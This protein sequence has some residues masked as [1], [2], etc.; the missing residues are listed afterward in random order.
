MAEKANGSRIKTGNVKRMALADL[1]PATYN[2]RTI[3]DLAKDGLKESLNKFG[4]LNLVV[5][6]E[7]SGNVVG[8]HQRLKVLQEQGETE[9]DVL[10]VSLDDKEEVAL[11][12]ALNNHAIQGDFSAE[13]LEA[14]KMT[15]VNLGDMFDKLQLKPIMNKLEKKIEK[16]KKKEAPM[17]KEETPEFEQKVTEVIIICPECK[18]RWRMRDGV[19][20][21][22]MVKK[23]DQQ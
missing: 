1:I 4:V 20:V 2:P 21:A 19:V 7:R 9:T 5:W 11:N 14:L 16:G 22:N 12:I 18:S 13:A 8:G 23:D 6:N 3:T 17:E 15:E 10:V